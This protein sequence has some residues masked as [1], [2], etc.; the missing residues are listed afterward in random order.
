[1][2]QEEKRKHRNHAFERAEDEEQA[3][4]GAE[5]KGKSG[6][7]ASVDARY[8]AKKEA[9]AA[10]GMESARGEEQIGI[11]AAQHRND[12]DRADDG[13]AKSAEDAIR[14]GAQNEIVAGNFVHGEDV[15]GHQIQQEI[16][17]HHSKDAAENGARDVAA[18][19]ANLFA[20]IDDTVPAID[21]VYNGLQSENDGDGKRPSSGQGGQSRGRR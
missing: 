7:A 13:I 11:D 10:H 20:E 17:P 2:C 9:V 5:K 15:Q 14:D 6:S 21:G 16:N 4:R 18:G 8:G 19:I 1:M 12:H 3:D